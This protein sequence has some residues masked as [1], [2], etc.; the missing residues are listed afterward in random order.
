MRYQLLRQTLLS[1]MS[2]S[3]L[4]TLGDADVGVKNEFYCVTLQTVM[5]ITP[6]SEHSLQSSVLLLYQK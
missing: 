2:L 3:H 6:T 1:A 5:S 4:C